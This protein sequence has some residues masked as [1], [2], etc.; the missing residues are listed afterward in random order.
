MER[1]GIRGSGVCTGEV[2][3]HFAPVSE[4]AEFRC[5]ECGYGVIVIRTPP[6][7]PMCGC[8]SWEPY[9]PNKWLISC[10]APTTKAT[11]IASST[12]SAM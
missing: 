10:Q 8:A 9:N 7:C 1:G 2:W 5:S 6:R 4:G 11:E 3:A 12:V